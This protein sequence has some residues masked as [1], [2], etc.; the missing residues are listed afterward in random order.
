MC[1]CVCACVCIHVPKKTLLG[2]WGGVSHADV[3][4][5]HSQAVKKLQTLRSAMFYVRK[6]VYV[7]LCVCACVCGVCI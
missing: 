5:N 4:A 1:L 7:W 2:L 6:R 3:A